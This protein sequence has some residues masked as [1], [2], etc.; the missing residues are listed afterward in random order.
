MPA[1][2]QKG[3][4]VVVPPPKTTVELEKRKTEKYE[5]KE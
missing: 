4:K 2:W 3:D 1:N 5:W